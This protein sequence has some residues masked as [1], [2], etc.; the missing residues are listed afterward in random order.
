MTTVIKR[1][2]L[3]T[4]ILVACA[5]MF[6]PDAQADP[7]LLG[8][9]IQPSTAWSSSSAI[10]SSTQPG[11]RTSFDIVFSNGT[12]CPPSL[13]QCEPQL[14][15]PQLAIGE[16]GTFIYTRENA[17]HFDL[18]A[19]LLTDST[20]AMITFPTFIFSETGG[21][22]GGHGV[23]ESDLFAPLLGGS[24]ATIDS[25]R[26]IVTENDLHVGT[27][28]TGP[29]FADPEKGTIYWSPEFSWEIWG[30]TVP[31]AV[32]V[33]SSLLLFVV[34]LVICLSAARIK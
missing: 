5:V 17:P 8:T 23:L 9:F 11:V 14:R 2:S 30:T 15:D 18:I 13:L 7:F 29:F 16:T 27:N 10:T 19:D 12:N 33:P 28:E 4:L 31:T 6:S 3:T 22:G 1:C 26:L 25:F 32:P 21:G 34:G 24:I 20:D